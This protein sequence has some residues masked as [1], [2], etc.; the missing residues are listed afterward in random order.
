[1]IAFKGFN[2][3]LTSVFG[4]GKKET[5][6]FHPG[7]TKQVEA[8]KTASSGFHC[9]ENPFGCLAFYS[10]D[11]RN[12]FFRVEAGGSIDEDADGKIACTEITLLEE[13]TP[14]QLAYEGMRY[15]VMYPDREDWKYT[16]NEVKVGQ[17]VCEA[18][19][20]GHIAIARG[21]N[22]RVKGPAGSIL[23]L[24]Q[25]NEKEITDAA[26]IVVKE[27]QADKWIYISSIRKREVDKVEKS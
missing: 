7:E 27:E 13:L 6:Q 17:D 4:N 14:V 2:E 12:R 8:S 5:C 9:C 22:P 20:A 24:V 11:R 10:L 25:E 26:L 19:A 18:K 15:I 16:Y 3:K 23:G 1:M 21:S